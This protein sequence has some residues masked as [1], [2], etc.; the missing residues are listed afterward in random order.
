MKKDNLSAVLDSLDQTGIYVVGEDTHKILYFN[1]WME[2]RTPGIKTG[3]KCHEV[4]REICPSC[5][6]DSVGKNSSSHTVHYNTVFGDAVDISANKTVWDGD[7]PAFII[8]ITPQVRRYDEVLGGQRIGEMYARSLVT[9]FNECVIANLTTDYYV[10]CQKDMM[11]TEIPE[12]GNFSSE[13]LR[14]AEITVHPDDLYEFRDNFTR[15]AMLRLFHEGKER[16]SKRLRRLMNGREYRMAEFTSSRIHTTDGDCWCVLVFRDVNEEYLLEQKK[17]LEI[18]QLATAA[19]VAY[20]LLIAVNLTQNSYYMV[21]YDQFRCKQA[22]DQG[23]FDE[24][25]EVGASTVDPEFRE[26]FRRKFSRKN[27][28]EAFARGEKQVSMELRQLDDNG[29][30]YWNYTQVVRV[31]SP[32]TDDVLEITMSRSIEEERRQQEIYL[33]KERQAKELMEEALQKAEAANRAKSDFLS[34]MSHDIRT[35]MNAI[36]GMTALAQI[37]LDQTGKLKEYLKNIETSGNHLLGLINEVLDVSKIESGN[38]RLEESEF[39]L[40]DLVEDT[41]LIVNPTILKKR[42]ELDVKLPETFHSC[43]KGDSQRIRQILVN[44]LDNAS[45]YTADGGKISLS[46]NEMEKEG[47]APGAYRFAVS[48]TGIGIR[49]EYLEH[50]FEPFS[51]A[52]DSGRKEAGTGLGLTIVRNL[53]EL[54][55]GDLQVESEYGA[56]TCFTVTLWLEPGDSSVSHEEAEAEIR[57]DFSGLKVLLAE[58]N[59]L[60]QQIA[61]EMLALFGVKVETVNNGQEA[62]E[63]VLRNPPFYYDL[64]FMDIQMPVMNGYEAARQIRDC[65]KERIRE[66]PIIAMTADAFTEDIKKSQISGMSGHLSKPISMDKLKRALSSCMRWKETNGRI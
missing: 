41:V 55:G 25:I 8:T 10:N 58:D 6:L 63:A 62:V 34:R 53:V 56:G 40:R 36:L 24:L 11:W 51:R 27:L 18:T 30:Y 33:R 45:K 7:I 31:E 61:E 13:N 52:D 28:L 46:L 4:W 15:D 3:M 35:P 23:D 54:M 21:E 17:N 1:K 66:L 19:R 20:Q 44:I 42:Q 12:S 5:P 59:L 2:K 64:I 26:E 39:D 29:E 32:Y 37:H 16:I 49:K 60:N 57:E 38:I 65:G 14:Y 50:I 22:K 43:V 47:G 9:V 48:D